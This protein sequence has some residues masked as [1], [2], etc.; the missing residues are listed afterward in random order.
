VKLSEVMHPPVTVS[1]LADIPTAAREMRDHNVGCVIVTSPTE[2][3]GII[4]DRDLTV[5]CTA[6]GHEPFA[7]QVEDH[8]SAPLVMV[9]RESDVLEAVHVMVHNEVKRLAVMEGAELVGVVSMSDIAEVMEM[10]L[11]ELLA[12]MG[13]SRRAT[14][15]ASTAR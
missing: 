3:V 5:R 4:T 1:R 8:M 11:Q 12:G 15:P 7:C 10:P 14:A 13:V 9:A 2:P 6:A